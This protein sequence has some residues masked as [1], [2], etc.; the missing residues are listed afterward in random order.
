MQ[1]Y[2]ER[3]ATLIGDPQLIRFTATE[4]DNAYQSAATRYTSENNRKYAAAVEILTYDISKLVQEYSLKKDGDGVESTESQ[5]LADVI[6]AR[7]LLINQY[8]EYITQDD[9]SAR[10]VGGFGYS[11]S[12]TIIKGI[13][14]HD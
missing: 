1:G 13:N 10:E 12:R 7:K 9:N 5:S 2:I 6:S 3:I 4:V 14:D 8:K 11:F